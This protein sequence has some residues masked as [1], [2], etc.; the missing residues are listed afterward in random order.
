MSDLS[1]LLGDV[2]SSTD[3]D[4]PAV[5]HEPPAAGREPV[6]AAEVAPSWTTAPAPADEHGSPGAPGQAGGWT[7][8]PSRDPGMPAMTP[9]ISV[10]MWTPGDDDILPNLR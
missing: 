1:N 7:A 4:G 6:Q 8:A 10:R 2:Y 9:P 5:R 3:P